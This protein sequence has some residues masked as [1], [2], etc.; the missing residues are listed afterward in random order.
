LMMSVQP[1]K[2]IKFSLNVIDAQSGQVLFNLDK[3]SAIKNL[4]SDTLLTRTFTFRMR[5][6]RNVILG[7]ELNLSNGI[8]ANEAL[9]EV[10]YLS[11]NGNMSKSV[12]SGDGINLVNLIPENFTLYQN[13]PNPF[14]ST[15]TIAFDLPE[16]VKVRLE[17]FD[18]S[19]RPICTLI[20]EPREA[21]SHRVFWN[22][23]DEAGDTVASGLYIY[24][25][26]AGEFIQSRKLLFIK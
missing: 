11:E 2:D 8:W 9:N 15:T 22:G 17:I 26:Q 3:W 10:Y 7:V 5:G 21:G 12:S 23:R 4:P 25:L 18:V 24:R 16:D 20:D 6:T 13:Y 19:G 1:G 14:N